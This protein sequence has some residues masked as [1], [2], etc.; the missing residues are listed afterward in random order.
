MAEDKGDKK[1]KES[2]KTYDAT[3]KILTER[4]ADD[5]AGFVAPALGLPAGLHAA[6]AN[7]NLSAASL[8][9][10]KLFR[11][12]GPLDGHLHI[13]F[14]A[15]WDGGL[16]DRTLVYAVLAERQLGTPV[17]SVVVLL[18]PRADA[19]S[20]TGT[21]RRERPDG[22]PYLEFRYGVIRVWEL[23]TAELLAGPVGTLPL[24]LL[25]DGAA[26]DLAGTSWRV[27]VR[28]RAEA[29]AEAGRTELLTAGDNLM[30]LRYDA[31]TIQALIPGASHMRESSTYRATLEEGR[32][33]ERLRTLQTLRGL[34]RRIGEK[35]LGPISPDAATAL[36]AVADADRLER[37]HDRVLDAAG[38]ADLLATP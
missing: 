17:H 19:S 37:I 33:E 8:D 36:G 26:A 3:T 29:P 4:H 13:E 23:L 2:P 35:K 14:Q 12:S 32:A 9:A 20:I 31:K 38:W 6:P 28:V 34:V 1:D 22:T 11:L 30:G 5:W 7:A 15:G 18:A 25:T 10:D 21:P 27:E 16:P 24:A